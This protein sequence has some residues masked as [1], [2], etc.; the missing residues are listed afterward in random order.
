[1]SRVWVSTTDPLGARVAGPGI[2]A[3]ELARGLH[4]AGHSVVLTTSGGLAADL[5]PEP[6][7]VRALGDA[8]GLARS[9]DAVVAQGALLDLH[10]GVADVDVP[11]AA[12]LY[13]PVHLESLETSRGD[14]PVHRRLTARARVA[15]VS[16]QLLRADLV[17]CASQRQRDLWTGHLAALGRVNPATYDD[18]AALRRLVVEVPF[19]LPSSPP[20][21][22]RSALRGT[23]VPADAYLLLWNGGVWPWFDP[24]TL[25]HAVA[26]VR[27][28][29]PSVRLHLMAEAPPSLL[30]LRESLGLD[31]V[32]T[33]GSWVPYDERADVLLDADVV[34]TTAREHL[35]T[36]Y[37]FR[38]RVLDALWCGLPVVATQGDVFADLVDRH[39]LGAAVPP[40]DVEALA[41]ALRRLADPAVRA[42]AADRVRAAAPAYRWPVVL[43]PLLAWA[44][45]PRH[46]PDLVDPVLGPR[47]RRARER[48]APAPAPWRAAVDVTAQRWRVEGAGGVARRVAARLPRRRG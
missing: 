16:R 11:Y 30:A 18:D 44:A 47:L 32:V 31:D 24:E 5:P 14:S 6:F 33:T 34:V 3:R 29:V 7:E 15:S 25:L 12:D 4:A 40:G 36:A 27:A 37:A 8:V 46:A 39:G 2:R 23:V 48:L 38:T 26:R 45:E 13:D 42:A 19:G 9:V 28:D 1:M 21:Q 10:P 41:V 17:L 22:Q 20:V 35:E 43:E